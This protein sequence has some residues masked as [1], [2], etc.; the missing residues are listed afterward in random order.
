MEWGAKAPS[1]E[2]I[3]C[4][5]GAPSLRGGHSPVS[6][7]PSLTGETQTCPQSSL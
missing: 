3:Q 1:E 4:L 7:S 5:R 2:R 6:G